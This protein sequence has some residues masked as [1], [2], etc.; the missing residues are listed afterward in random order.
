MLPIH[1]KPLE[2]RSTMV[3]GVPGAS[4]DVAW[5]TTAHAV[6]TRKKGDECRPQRLVVI[7]RSDALQRAFHR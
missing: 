1:N 3:A 6:K 2:K 7:Q 4:P 5:K